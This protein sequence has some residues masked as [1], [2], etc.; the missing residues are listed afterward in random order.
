V[1]ANAEQLDIAEGVK[2]GLDAFLPKP[3]KVGDLLAI[4]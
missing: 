2:A 4:I 3:L 1:S